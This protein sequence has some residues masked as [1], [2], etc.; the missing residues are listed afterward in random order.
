M[1]PTRRLFGLLLALPLLLVQVVAVAEEKVFPP[2]QLDQLVAPIA[3]YPDSVVAQIMMASTYPLEVVQAQRWREQNPN[4]KDAELDS[5]GA[6]QGWDGSVVSLLHFPDVLKK[7]SD[8]LDWTQDLG[9]AVLAQQQDV[10]SAVQR[11][12]KKA[13]EEGNLQTTEQQKVIV[14]QEVIRI[15]PA[16]EV[17]YVPAYNPTVVYGGWAPPP[18]YPMYS[19]PPSYWYPP[20]YALGAGLIGFG[21]GV[22]WAD[23]VWGDCDWGHGDI[24]I[25]RNTNINRNVN[26]INGKWQHNASHRQGV[27]Y[28][29]NSTRQ[30][31]DQASR[32]ARDQR[33]ARDADRGFDRSGAGGRDGIG[34]DR[35]GALGDRDGASSRDRD[36]ASRDRGATAARDRGAA[37]SRDRGTSAARD[38]GTAGSRDVG[39]GSRASR[40]SS[41]DRGGSAF[42]S[43]RS[44][45][46]ARAA[47]SRGSSSRSGMSRSGGARGGGGGRR[48]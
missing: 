7:M 12:R 40:G 9:D 22:A 43:S 14:E 41:Y 2:D 10:M 28:R 8:N 6:A 1:N 37:S 42:S 27:R 47:S 25:N 39:S 13:Q 4:L 34:G 30:R 19:Y 26:N 45:S 24:N 11:M 31:Y 38:R 35:G 20:G 44:G 32:Q 23:A 16:T 29:D 17:V 33:I 48:R 46:S 3:L 36:L 15:E 5:Q 21:L 18:Y